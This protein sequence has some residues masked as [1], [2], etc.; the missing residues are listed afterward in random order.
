MS[1]TTSAPLPGWVAEYLIKL[2]DGEGTRAER[3]RRMAGFRDL[4]WESG[5][6]LARIADGLGISRQAVEQ[7][8][9]RGVDR[10]GHPLPPMPPA[11]VPRPVPAR[12]RE[13][14]R[15]RRIAPSVDP[16][17]AAR[18][19]ELV[20]LAAQV[21]GRTALD[22]P[23]RAAGRELA[24][25]QAKAVHEGVSIQRIADTCGQTRNAVAFRLGRY[26]YNDC[27]PEWTR[28]YVERVS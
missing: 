24:R 10:A 25:L 20:P 4:L 17:D 12:E 6:P 26:G 9:G 11:P 2:R 19:R 5:W 22:S 28:E 15:V 7:W 14:D 18:M 8:G 27:I 21:N 16:V 13:R 23:L 3:Y 1:R